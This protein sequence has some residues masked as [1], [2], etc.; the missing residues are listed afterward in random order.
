MQT[1]QGTQLTLQQTTDKVRYIED[2]NSIRWFL[3]KDVGQKL[4]LSNY[5]RAIQQYVDTSNKKLWLAT[6]KGGPHQ[7]L[8]LTADGITQLALTQQGKRA[9]N[10]PASTH[11]TDEDTEGIRTVYDSKGYIWYSARDVC[12][13]I[14]HGHMSRMLKRYVSPEN[15]QLI[16]FEGSSRACYAVNI[17]GFLEIK[18]GRLHHK[19]Q[20][21]VA[22]ITKPADSKEE[23]IQ[24]LEEKPLEF[25]DWGWIPQNASNIRP[26]CKIIGNRVA[27]HFTHGSNILLKGAGLTYVSTPML[28]GDKSR[29]E[30][31]S[32]VFNSDGFIADYPETWKVEFEAN[33]K[34]TRV[35][36][37]HQ[38]TL[39][40][41]MSDYIQSRR[42]YLRKKEEHSKLTTQDW[43][44]NPQ[45][46]FNPVEWFGAFHYTER[47]NAKPVSTSSRVTCTA[48]LNKVLNSLS[49]LMKTGVIQPSLEG[50]RYAYN[51]TFQFSK[52]WI[53]QMQ[54]EALPAPVRVP[55]IL[56]RS[57]AGGDV[58]NPYKYACNRLLCTQLLNP[59]K[60][61]LKNKN[62]VLSMTLKQYCYF[63]GI[64]LFE[65]WAQHTARSGGS[66]YLS[67]KQAAYR[68][69]MVKNVV[70]AYHLF[71][72]VGLDWKRR[73]YCTRTEQ[74]PAMPAII[75]IKPLY[76]F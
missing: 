31:I 48:W 7:T 20:Q 11:L 13:K 4:G 21:V 38:L 46:I 57:F 25:C 2:S 60:S 36:A 64:P 65:D 62:G 35:P 49:Y 61:G 45:F 54:S 41:L 12:L 17:A 52:D 22:S 9:C 23:A 69:H 74:D 47:V 26:K 29:P 51:Y 37:K 40:L 28:Q 10:T 50:E 32:M 1:E 42:V 39:D 6:S 43:Q 76:C 71:Q 55:P 66:A 19:A 73:R 14:K 58:S 5:R 30:D 34:A 68:D 72:F 3:A 24:T 27:I 8:F 67:S 56:G 63:T 33:P 18:E 44:D 53:S 16:A 70:E 59:A 15:Q 75:Y